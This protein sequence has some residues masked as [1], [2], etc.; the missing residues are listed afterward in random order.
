MLRKTSFESFSQASFRKAGNVCSMNK[1]EHLF[2]NLRQFEDE[3]LLNSTQLT[4]ACSKSPIETV[5][6]SEKYVQS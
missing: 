6:K 2:V 3:V 5:E 1:K 4:F